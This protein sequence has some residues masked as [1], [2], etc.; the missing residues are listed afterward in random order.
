MDVSKPSRRGVVWGPRA[1]I[2]VVEAVEKRLGSL[3]VI[4]DF[5]RRIDIAG[6]ID[7]A[8][9]I[10]DLAYA[11]HGQVIEVL[12]ANRLTSPVAMVRIADWAR[13]WAVPEVFGVSADLL[14]DDRLGR[15]LDAVAEQSERIIG[16]VGAAAIEAFGIDVTRLH[17]DMT[18]ISLYGSY[19]DSDPAYPAPAYGHP[20]DRRS[21]LQQIQAGIAVSGDGGIPVWHRAYDGGAGE[22]AQVVDAMGW[23]KMLAG[24][25]GFLLVGDSKLISYGNVTAMSDGAVTFI[26]PLAAA[27]VPAGL[28]A[29]LDRGAAT[30]VDYIAERD[31]DKP[32]WDRCRYRVTEDVMRMPGRRKR[33]PVHQLR[34][35]LVHSTANQ[36]A[37]GKARRRQLDAARTDLDTL[38]RTAG[39]RY[40]PTIAA[41][42]AK[43][44]EITRR[45]RVTGYPQT[46]ITTGPDGKP[47]FSWSYDQTAIDAD[48]AAD[49]WYAL[50][51]NLPA[52]IDAGEVLH[53]Y[54]EQPTVERRYSTIKGPLAV[55]PIFLQNN[56]RI[57][58]LITVICLALL[59]FC[60]IER[61]VRTQLAPDTDMSGFY[62]DGRAVPPTGRLI[63]QALGE[64]RLVPAH[65][66]K[67]PKIPQP[68]YLQA[69]LLALL[70][71]DPTQ[72]RGS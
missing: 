37:A 13:S 54:K 69:K 16:S 15:A 35:I 48:A 10:R 70:N 67:P 26:A 51:T 45:R 21:D 12:I 71:V 20:K 23:L 3:P 2:A 61:E 30:V 5:C 58:A 62:T 24:P 49:G 39:T 65:N 19:V 40:H 72:P 41:V 50:L 18:S 7:Q 6:I 46:S 57:A 36:Q 29:G 34:R 9:P 4:A 25:R 66:G 63:L 8:C 14:D 38:V 1:E 59:I 68:G 31:G 33:D 42:T 11:T 44:A 32:F 64:L 43:A 27:R 60:L 55:A 47:V 52:D 56:R 28:F 53:R 22:V 17:W